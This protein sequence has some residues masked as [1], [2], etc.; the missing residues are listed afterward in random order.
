MLCFYYVVCLYLMIFKI[1]ILFIRKLFKKKL[2]WKIDC[3][4]RLELEL[5]LKWIGYLIDEFDLNYNFYLTFI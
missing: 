1:I 2:W 5:E 3:A 4:L